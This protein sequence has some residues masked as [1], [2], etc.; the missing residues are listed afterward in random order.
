MNLIGT[1]T[2]KIFFVSNF[3][4]VINTAEMAMTIKCKISA[5]SITPLK[6]QAD[7]TSP[8]LPFKVKIQQNFSMANILILYKY[9]KQNTL[10]VA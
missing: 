3:C 10:G 9:F 1:S 8:Y 7:F 2:T 5:V 4:G 6:S